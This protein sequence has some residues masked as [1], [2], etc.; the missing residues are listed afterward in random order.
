MLLRQFWG[1]RGYAMDVLSA[2]ILC[3]KRKTI[4]ASNFSSDGEPTDW[5]RHRRQPNA[6]K[7]SHPA[8][9]RNQIQFLWNNN[10]G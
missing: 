3:G 1:Q 10:F 4:I 6:L 2:E 7:Q 8:S 9:N 5:Q